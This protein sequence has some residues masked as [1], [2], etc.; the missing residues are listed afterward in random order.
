MQLVKNLVFTESE[1]SLTN[2]YQS[3]TNSDDDESY[4]SKYPQFVKHLEAFW[5]RRQEWALSFRITKT[6]RNNHT[7]NYAEASVR[8]IKEVV[9]G[10]VK[11]FN[12]IQMFDFFSCTMEKYYTNRLFDLAHSRYRPGISLRFKRVFDTENITKTEQLS[13]SI[14][15]VTETA[16]GKDYDF[17]V[18]MEL[19]TCSCLKGVR[20]AE[21]KHQAVIAKTFKS[22]LLISLHSSLNML[23][24]LLLFLQLEKT[25][26]WIWISMQT[27]GMKL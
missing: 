14:Y 11:A 15:W 16:E 3:L 5:E 25:K 24:E 27:L 8:I 4:A 13:D 23:G 22:F 19:A 20:G 1:E 9:F 12:L 10:R 18:D 6:F 21:C 17:L 2:I 7:N 26:L